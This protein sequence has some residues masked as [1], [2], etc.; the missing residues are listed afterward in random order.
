VFSEVKNY[1]FTE[2][3]INTEG[4]K[5]L[6][7][8]KFFV[9]IKNY[10]QENLLIKNFSSKKKMIVSKDPVSYSRFTGDYSHDYYIINRRRCKKSLPA[11]KE[12]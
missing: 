1:F 7:F 2:M 4:K 12:L 9:D 10:N 11:K 5:N 8:R 3:L 6:K